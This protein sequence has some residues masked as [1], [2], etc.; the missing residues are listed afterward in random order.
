MQNVKS[1]L[2]LIALVFTLT[3]VYSQELKT[4][5]LEDLSAFK[6]QAGN[7]QIVGDVTI[8]P[9]IDIH[10][11][12]VQ[13]PVETGKKNKK[14]KKLS[15]PEHPMAVTYSMG[16]GILL[17]MNNEVK[18]DNLVTAFEHG[19]IELELAPSGRWQGAS[20]PSAGAPRAGRRRAP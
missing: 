13:E 6:P 16:R 18:K 17:N 11:P 5:A 15:S 9:N 1:Y 19:D 12:Q 10:P 14:S 8:N 7:W 20:G 4:L 3:G 2:V